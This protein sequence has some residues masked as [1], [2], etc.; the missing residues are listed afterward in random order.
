MENS[1]SRITR[2]TPCPTQEKCPLG[3][4]LG[5]LHMGVWLAVRAG[6]RWAG[7][8]AGHWPLATQASSQA[9]PGHSMELH[10]HTHPHGNS[11]MTCS[12]RSLKY[13]N[14]C[15]TLKVIIF[16]HLS[17]K[18]SWRCP[19]QRWTPATWLVGHLKRLVC[20]E[21]PAS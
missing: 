18:L 1:G 12:Q 6:A 19:C 20:G 7:L 10:K 17:D 8:S 5:V 16:V 2:R 4:S 21:H 3:D 11:A 15:P 14:Q 9:K 13:Y